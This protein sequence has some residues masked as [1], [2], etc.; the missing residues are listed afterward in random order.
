[1]R[2]DRKKADQNTCGVNKANN[3]QVSFCLGVGWLNVGGAFRLGL[4]AFHPAVL[5]AL[6]FSLQRSRGL[7]RVV[8]ASQRIRRVPQQTIATSIH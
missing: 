7:G 1:M 3:N 4:A 6:A 8:R 2:Q 5:S